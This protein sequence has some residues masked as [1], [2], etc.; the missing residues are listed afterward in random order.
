VC[1]A[2]FL[3][4]V[5]CTLNAGGVGCFMCRVGQSPIYTACRYTVSLAER[6]PNIRSYTVH[7]YGSGQP[8]LC[9]L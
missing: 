3:S 1:G 6:L 9:V 8:Y 2:A 7:I 4:G 5:T